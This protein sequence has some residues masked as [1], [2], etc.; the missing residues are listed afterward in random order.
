MKKPHRSEALII[1]AGPA[2]ASLAVWLAK[3]G[4]DCILVDRATF[5]RKKPCASCFSPHCFPFLERLGLAD[6]VRTGQLVRYVDLQTP[7]RS[8]RIDATRHPFGPSFY[9][10]QRVEFD[11]LLVDHARMLSVRIME[12]VSIDG[13][14]RKDG[15]V[16][17][18]R[19][20]DEEFRAD[21]TVV[22]TG[23]NMKFL[24]ANYRPSVRAYQTITGWY[25]GYSDP[26]TTDSFTAPWL[27]GT[28][29]LYPES[30][31]RANVGIMVH[32]DLL[33]AS[34]K[35]LRTLFEAYLE[36][37]YIRE[38]LK[39]AKQIG[40]LSGSPIRYTMRPEGIVDDGLIMIGEACLLTHPN[41]GEGI[42][43]A[44]RSADAAVKTLRNA[45]EAGTYDRESLQPYSTGIES[46]F[47]RNFRK[48]ALMRRWTDNPFLY[49]TTVMAA[50][51][52]PV[53]THWFEK[54]LDR[55]A[56]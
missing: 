10:Y 39:R 7:N 52:L 5:P 2:G 25:Q 4:W 38:R 36:T 12:G 28:G 27:M 35:N 8:A 16:V 14:L 56:L 53:V 44:F 6:M 3:E 20:G 29:W 9:V 47:G 34:E 26:E 15:R 37:P 54:R 49:E 43:Q 48:A 18:A 1:G 51:R 21:V 31:E 24:P 30:V 45:R 11:A 42:S 46:M 50:R 40:R 41:T 17:G 13:L 32:E 19:A 33:R 55:L 23:S 22:A